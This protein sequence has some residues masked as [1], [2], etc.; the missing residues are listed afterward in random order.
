[1]MRIIRLFWAA[2]LAMLSL[3]AG[4]EVPED[5]AYGLVLQAEA[6][7]PVQRLELP[8][9]VYRGVV[10]PDLADLRVFNAAGQLVPHSLSLP[11]AAAAEPTWQTVPFFPLPANVETPGTVLELAPAPEGTVLRWRDDRRVAEEARVAAYVLDLSDVQRPTD[12]LRLSWEA[13]DTAGLLGPLRVDVSDDLQHWRSLRRDASVAK[14]RYDGY[15]LVQDRIE[16]PTTRGRYMR[17]SWP[18]ESTARLIG[19]ELRLQPKQA[20][21]PRRWLEVAPAAA[22]EP[23]VWLYDTEGYFPVD[24]LGLGFASVNQ[25]AEVEISSRQTAE[26][27]WRARHRGVFYRLRLEAGELVSTPQAVSRSS[28]TLWKLSGSLEAPRLQLGWT[29]HELLFLASGEGPYLLAYGSRSA[30]RRAM[31]VKQ[32]LRADTEADLLGEAEVTAMRELGGEQR[33]RDPLPW[34]QWLLWAVLLAAVVLLATLVWRLLK[35]SRA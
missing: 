24:R 14:L 27:A 18:E 31:P 16:L 15:E 1:M 28:D 9:A 11:T 26:Q 2:F 19:V 20:A 3:G 4:A 21:V 13:E 22:L 23:S 33:L 7:R 32:L 10:Q 17:L 34:L 5:F 6:G 25:F 12:A 8:E 35:S 30:N 29:P